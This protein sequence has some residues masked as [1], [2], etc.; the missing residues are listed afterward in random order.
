MFNFIKP[1]KNVIILAISLA[2]LGGVFYWGYSTSNKSWSAKWLQRNADD[3]QADLNF[4][5]EQGRIEKERLARVDEIQKNAAG[6]KARLAADLARARTESG[7]LQQ[8]IKA[9]LEQLGRGNDTA[10]IGSGQNAGAVGLL[11][12]DLYAK[13]NQRSTELAGEADAYYLA[14]QTCNRQYDAVRAVK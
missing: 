4:A 14:G 6:E 13:I 7:R 1:Y 12:A 3:L 11:L 5:R 9:A 8:S 2:L 10:V